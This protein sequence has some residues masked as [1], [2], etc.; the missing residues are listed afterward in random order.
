VSGVEFDP[1][2]PD[3]RAPAPVIA[4]L[5]TPGATVV[6]EGEAL[7]AAGA[8]ADGEL[9]PRL[10]ALREAIRGASVR[11]TIERGGRIGHGWLGP[12]RAV[13]AHPLAGRRA[14][15]TALPPALLIDAL[16]RLNDLGPR[17]RVEPAVRIAAAPGA[18]AAALADRAPER[19]PLSDPDQA[20]AF[21]ALLTGLRE[22]WRV[23]VAWDPAERQQLG[24]RRLEV[25]D[26]DGGY[27]LVIPDDPTVE[28]WPTTPTAVFRALCDLFP[29]PSEVRAWIPS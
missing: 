15:V 28:L 13:L 26:T 8:I 6:P 10:D 5:A 24:G 7:E 11:L 29:Q 22:H 20:A 18:L 17:P 25:L 2:I 9:H 27:W 14:R 3:L 21:A 16:V 1:A 12:D 4:W 19:V 23:T